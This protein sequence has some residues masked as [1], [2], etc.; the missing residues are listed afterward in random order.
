MNTD[1]LIEALLSRAYDLHQRIERAGFQALA[2]PALALQA[3]E[4]AGTVVEKLDLALWLNGVGEPTGAALELEAADHTVKL[5][6]RVVASAGLNGDIPARISVL[7]RNIYNV[8]NHHL[9]PSIEADEQ[10]PR[11]EG[12][13]P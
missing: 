1:R 9:L 2:H 10:W 13:E 6:D 7:A 4:L 5:L 8:M 11:H 3:D 12:E